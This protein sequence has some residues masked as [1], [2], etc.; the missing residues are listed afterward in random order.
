MQLWRGVRVMAFAT[1]MAVIPAQAGT[2][3][4]FPPVLTDSVTPAFAGVTE[5]RGWGEEAG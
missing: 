5:F 2:K 3:P 1:D 4:A